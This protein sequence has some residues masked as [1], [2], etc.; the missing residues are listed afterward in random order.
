MAIISVK[1]IVD[2]EQLP[3]FA[4]AQDLPASVIE[5]VGLISPAFAGQ[6]AK[7]TVKVQY[8]VDSTWVT[9]LIQ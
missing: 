8:R 7:R 3:P 9:S 1:V 4:R 6:R 5:I 2:E